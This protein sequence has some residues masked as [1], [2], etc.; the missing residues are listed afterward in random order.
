MPFLHWAVENWFDLL[1][2]IGIIGGLLFTAFS[3]RSESKTRRISNL[4]KITENHR[5]IWMEFSRRPGLHRILEKHPQLLNHSP[6]TG[7]E[8]IFVNSVIFHLNSAFEAMKNHLFIKPEGLRRDVAMFFSLP[9]PRAVWERTKLLQNDD[10]VA[11]VDS[12]LSSKQELED[13]RH[14]TT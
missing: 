1:N 5:E 7:D 11:F 3:L 2:A 12:C 13:N 10:F 6:Y 9:I 14:A 8:E 4:L